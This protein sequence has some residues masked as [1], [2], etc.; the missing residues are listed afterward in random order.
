MINVHHKTFSNRKNEREMGMGTII[1]Q[2]CDHTI[3]HFDDEKVTTLYAKC[4]DCC[5][6]KEK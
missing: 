3:E 5:G 6:D 1:C 2:D 4:N